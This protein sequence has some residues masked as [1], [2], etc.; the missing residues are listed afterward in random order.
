MNL[1]AELR[2]QRSFRV[3]LGNAVQEVTRLL[4]P[5]SIDLKRSKEKTATGPE[6]HVA[7]LVRGLD[8]GCHQLSTA[9]HLSFC[10]VKKSKIGTSLDRRRLRE[11]GIPRRGALLEARRSL[12][13][14]LRLHLPFRS[15]ER[16]ERTQFF[17][18]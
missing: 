10:S 11:G 13:R 2:A 6:G 1:C 12:T 3:V 15:N 9:L 18:R 14:T 5:P 4:Q 16:E 17:V 7:Q 8:A